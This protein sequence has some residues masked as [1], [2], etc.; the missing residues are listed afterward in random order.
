MTLQLEPV[1]QRRAR[2][3]WAER[4]VVAA[5]LVALPSGGLLAAWT[6]GDL[7]VPE[8]PEAAQVL[9]SPNRTAPSVVL[10]EPLSVPD[11]RPRVAAPEMRVSDAPGP[12]QA[13]TVPAPEITAPAVVVFANC[14][15]ARAAG[16]APIVAGAP[17]YRPELDRDGDGTAC[18]EAAV[19][20]TT[21]PPANPTS[22]PPS[23]PAQPSPEPTAEPT[24]T[25]P[26][27]AIPGS[28]TRARPDRGSVD[29]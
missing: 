27:T 13:R 8:R 10:I 1:L 17:G 4:A 14:D 18:D 22:A 12:A 26:L 29:G 25:A 19:D 6:N 16:A 15:E 2:P 23:S 24:T 28:R 11:P 20:P 5:A 3:W 21:Q 9:P 7:D